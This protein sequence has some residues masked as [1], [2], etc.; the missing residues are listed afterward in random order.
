MSKD[1]KAQLFKD[2][3]ATGDILIV[4]KSSAS[5]RRLTKTIVDM[6]GKRN[7]VHSVAHFS[8]AIEIIDSKKPKLILSDYEVNG[9]YCSACDL[10]R[11]AEATFSMYEDWLNHYPPIK[12]EFV[13]VPLYIHVGM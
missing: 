2:F 6:G 12:E 13:P 11:F 8:E 1:K 4:D 5:R 3:L 7:Q 10:Y 9:G